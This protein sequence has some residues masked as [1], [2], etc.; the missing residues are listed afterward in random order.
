ML[1]FNASAVSV[2]LQLHLHPV[3][4]RV[5]IETPFNGDSRGV[6]GSSTR[7][8][9]KPG[10]DQGI[11]GLGGAKVAV[12]EDKFHVEEEPVQRVD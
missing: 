5:R 3:L 4:R 12:T 6:D 2:C 9:K 8:G 1:P 10:L 11:E 7:Q